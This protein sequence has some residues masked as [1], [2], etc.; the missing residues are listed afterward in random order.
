LLQLI[1]AATNY[2]NHSTG[3]LSAVTCF[4]L[5]FGAVVRVF[6]TI[7]ETGDD[8]LLLT[9]LCTSTMNGIIAGQ[10]LWYWNADKHKKKD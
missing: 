2:K 6:T 7:Q 10:V 8:I 4:M 5:F 3:Q 1:Q 9:Y